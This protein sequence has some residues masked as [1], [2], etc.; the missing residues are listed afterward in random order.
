MFEIA[1]PELLIE[2]PVVQKELL[3]ML[4][5]DKVPAP[6]SVN[7][8]ERFEESLTMFPKTSRLVTDKVLDCSRML[9]AYKEPLALT[10]SLY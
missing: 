5:S 2:A 9:E 7:K 1:E 3:V 4:M 10:I 6:D 8:P